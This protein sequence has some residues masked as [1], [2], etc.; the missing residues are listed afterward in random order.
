MFSASGVVCKLYVAGNTLMPASTSSW[1]ALVFVACRH[2]APPII[3]S[4][5]QDV[6]SAGSMALELEQPLHGY[7]LIIWPPAINAGGLKGDGTDSRD[8][9]LGMV[10]RRG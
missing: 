3:I 2:T 9:I 1:A 8:P 10:V 5:P 6:R 4:Y 7:S